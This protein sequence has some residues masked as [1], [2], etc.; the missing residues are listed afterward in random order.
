MWAAIINTILG[1]WLMVAPAVLGTDNTIADNDHIVGPLIA[2]FAVISWFEATRVT[3]LYNV[4]LG[5]WLVLAPW[6]LGYDN[7]LAIFND[8][9]VGLTVVALSFVKGKITEKFGGGWAAIWQEKP[10]HAQQAQKNAKD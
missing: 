3:R 1:I 2:S 7:S 10:L 5:L 6:V 9:A 8:M 4:P